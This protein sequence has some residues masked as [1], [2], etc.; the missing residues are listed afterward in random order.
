[1]PR[2]S[3]RQSSGSDPGGFPCPIVSP[4]FSATHRLGQTRTRLAWQSIRLRLCPKIARRLEPDAVGYRSIRRHSVARNLLHRCNTHASLR[5]GSA[6]RGV[7]GAQGL[8]ESSC[9]TVGLTGH[10][11]ATGVLQSGTREL[12][13]ELLPKGVDRILLNGGPGKAKSWGSRQAV[14]NSSSR[15]SWRGTF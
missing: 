8:Q 12:A 4:A 2:R 10:A 9:A 5:G 1:M 3:R 6:R 15:R 14:A 11:P 13:L 7:K